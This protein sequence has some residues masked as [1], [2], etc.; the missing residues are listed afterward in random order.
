MKTIKT[1]LNK[2]FIA[3]LSFVTLFVCA[4]TF[5]MHKA[6]A[7]AE[8]NNDPIPEGV[9]MAYTAYVI[10]DIQFTEDGDPMCFLLDSQLFERAENP[11]DITPSTTLNDI[12]ASPVIQTMAQDFAEKLG[13]I[14][15]HSEND[16]IDAQSIFAEIN[17]NI[18]IHVSNRIYV[19]VTTGNSRQINNY[20]DLSNWA[21]YDA[22][23]TAIYAM[24]VFQTPAAFYNLLVNTQRNH[25]GFMAAYALDWDDVGNSGSLNVSIYPY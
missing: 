7:S 9:L 19:D 5:P 14:A 4:F 22:S 1:K 16:S 24:M 18:I 10:Q 20:E 3:M 13:I 11:I 8:T 6:S 25:S 23:S 21:F 12:N 17:M 15:P 2:F